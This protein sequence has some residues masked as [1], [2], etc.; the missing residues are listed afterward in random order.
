MMRRGLLKGGDGAKGLL[1][2]PG[3]EIGTLTEPFE[4]VFIL[5]STAMSIS[6]FLKSWAEK[7]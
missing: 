2:G 3:N 4:E 7:A 5:Y 6:G 1:D